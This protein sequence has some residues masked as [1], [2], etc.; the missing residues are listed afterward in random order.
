MRIKLSHFLI[1][2]SVLLAYAA[3]GETSDSD[4]LREVQAR[5]AEN[6]VRESAIANLGTNIEVRYG[7][8]GAITGFKG[9]IDLPSLS[10]VG[11]ARIVD[12]L[13]SALRVPLD[14]GDSA[15]LQLE[16]VRND[17]G[18]GHTLR[19][20][21]AVAGIPVVGAHL[22][23]A[24]QD[25]GGATLV[26]ARLISDRELPREPSIT[27]S[28]ASQRAAGARPFTEAHT[29]VEGTRLVYLYSRDAEPVLAWENYVEGNLT[30]GSFDAVQV[31]I[32]AKS[33]DVL[34]VWPTIAHGK[35]RVVHSAENTT[36]NCNT[37]RITEGGSTG[38]SKAMNVYNHTGT[39][40][41]FFQSAFGRS[42]YIGATVVY[43]QEG[44]NETGGGSNERVRATVRWCPSGVCPGNYNNAGFHYGAAFPTTSR[45]RFGN[46]DPSGS[47]VW[48][49][50]GDSLDMV[51]HEY[52][53]GIT[54]ADGNIGLSGEAG[55]I[56]EALSDIFASAVDAYANGLSSASWR[57]GEDVYQPSNSNT[58]IRIMS[59]PKAGSTGNPMDDYEHGSFAS[60]GNHDKAGVANLA[61]YLLTQGGTH[62][63]GVTSNSVTGIGLTK[64][65]SVFY[66]AIGDLPTAALFQELRA[67]V[68]NR[69]QIYGSSEVSSVHQAFD[70][71][72]VPGS[73]NVPPDMPA[74]ISASSWYC[75]GWYTISWPSVAGATGYDLRHKENI[76]GDYL[77]GTILYVGTSTSVDVNVESTGYV[78]VRACN[79]S[80]CS[81]FQ[82]TAY[83]ERQGFCQ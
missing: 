54:R 59:D 68:A 17:A 65:R 13:L 75:Y 44:C 45:M 57:I 82:G 61:F 43:G 53:H 70:A 15:G 8:H 67:A 73:P 81:D 55:G 39:A 80:G 79:T 25:D 37:H 64:A 7:D 46:G 63:R 32:D 40:F 19:F 34:A 36:G 9:Q 71:V 62:P 50:W 49:Y 28:D 2:A 66:N 1:V 60:A 76:G 4:R 47:P 58:A 10:E 27:A 33:G 24:Y 6:E 72:R 56:N 83:V 11:K 5:I 12:E 14:L 35:W 18:G 52:M 23:V 77:L 20:S 22:A 31:F 78:G 42:T 26:S 51:A 16:N 3:A 21:Q 48:G 30:D 41:N 74:S 38:D 29:I 69:A